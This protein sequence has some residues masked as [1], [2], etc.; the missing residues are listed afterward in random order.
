MKENPDLESLIKHL[1][2]DTKITVEKHKF[3][4]EGKPYFVLSKVVL[5][6]VTKIERLRDIILEENPIAKDSDQTRFEIN[7]RFYNG[8]SFLALENAI[9]FIKEQFDGK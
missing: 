2:K 5:C 1:L 6:K 7:G 8:G 4:R 3:G 9:N